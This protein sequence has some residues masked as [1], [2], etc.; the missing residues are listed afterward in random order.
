M[1]SHAGLAGFKSLLEEMSAVS[2]DYVSD[3]GRL[4]TNTVEGFHG[5]ALVYRG[6]R[7]DLCHTHYVCKTNMAICH[8][9]SRIGH[10]YHIL[11]TTKSI[12]IVFN[13]SLHWIF[14]VSVI[15]IDYLGSF[16]TEVLLSI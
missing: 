7:T 12:L 10:Q 16:I 4:T 8:K 1:S 6:K 9:V 11:C 5:M 14:E 13:L 2:Q 15:H 3:H